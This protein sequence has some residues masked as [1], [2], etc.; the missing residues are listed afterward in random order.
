MRLRWEI[1]HLTQ[2][3]V[4]RVENRYGGTVQIV[5]NG[6]KWGQ[7]TVPLDDPVV[8]HALVAKRIVRVFLDDTPLC[9]GRITSPYHSDPE[10]GGGEGG[11]TLTVY[12]SDPSWHLKRAFTKGF[13]LQNGVDQSQIMANLV[14]HAAGH[15][16]G[17]IA[18]TLWTGGPDRIML[19]PDGSEIWAMLE[20]M[21]ELTDGPDF[22]LEP[23]EA[24]TGTLAKLNTYDEQGEDKTNTVQLQYGFGKHTASGF[25]YQ[26]QGED[27]CNYYLAIG[28][29]ATEGG[30]VP[31]VRATSAGSVAE[32]GGY[33]EK[34]EVFSD[35]TDTNVLAEYAKKY[36]REH[37][38]AMEQFD[39]W[40]DPMNASAT[41]GAA[42]PPRIAPDGDAWLGDRIKLEVRRNIAV[43]ATG[44][45]EGII[46]TEDDQGA[47][48][49]QITCLP[50]AI[51]ASDV[52]TSVTTVSTVGNV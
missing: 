50:E 2:A 39:V 4:A 16:H 12:F 26:P 31:A 46:Y 11:A 24:T 29:P 49:A 22:E 36:V 17:V 37:A 21:A 32:Y 33:F 6:A 10:G 28:T 1:A 9:F 13:A 18:G 42:V 47:V 34:V 43:D 20:K 15:G 40:T 48:T 35:V 8:Q 3:P 25:T 44:R 30:A 19:Y 7:F 5:R 23:I 45:I 41:P 27:I 52:T 51:A 38:F 14:A